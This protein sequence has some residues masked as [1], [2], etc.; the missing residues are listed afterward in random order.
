MTRRKPDIDAAALSALADRVQDLVNDIEA[1][2]DR[3]PMRGLTPL[4]VAEAAQAFNRMAEAAVNMNRKLL[5]LAR[6]A[7]D[8]DELSA[9]LRAGQ[10]Q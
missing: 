3:V 7:A 9:R 1:A 10:G 2:A 8:Q 5:A 6:N 4:Q